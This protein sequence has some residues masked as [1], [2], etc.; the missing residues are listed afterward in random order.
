MGEALS[1]E[2]VFPLPARVGAYRPLARIGRGGVADVYAAIDPLGEL[3]ALKVQHT[4]STTGREALQREFQIQAWVE[5]P[6]LVTAFD[7]GVL[8]DGRGWIALEHV[9][10][11]VARRWVGDERVSGTLR[12]WRTLHVIGQVAHALEALHARGLV[13]AD[14][15]PSNLLV[16]ADGT[17]RLMDLGMARLV[18][19][20]W[21]RQGHF[22]GTRRYASP[23]QLRGDALTPAAD[24]FALGATTYALLRGSSPF[25][26]ELERTDAPPPPRLRGIHPLLAELLLAT[27]ESDPAARPA[28]DEL[29]EMLDELE[30]PEEAVAP[31]EPPPT[32]AFLPSHEQLQAL[33]AI[34]GEPVEVRVLAE[35]TATD[36]ETLVPLLDDLAAGGLADRDGASWFTEQAPPPRAAWND[37][38]AEALLQGLDPWPSLARAHALHHLDR[39][40]EAAAEALRAGRVSS[41]LAQV[42]H[43]GL[44][45]LRTARR[46]QAD[47]SLLDDHA[48]P[49]LAPTEDTPLGR[50]FRAARRGEGAQ[51]LRLAAAALAEGAAPAPLAMLRARGLLLSGRHSSARRL[52]E[53]AVKPAGERVDRCLLLI[54]LASVEHQLGRN[55]LARDLL[56]RA[57]GTLP[58]RPSNLLL[59]RWLRVQGEID[60]ATGRPPAADLLREAWV[61]A[62]EGGDARVLS[63]LDV[64]ARRDQPADRER[65]EAI[66][67]A[68][69]PGEDLPDLASALALSIHITGA[70]PEVPVDVAA[71]LERPGA[72]R[73][74]LQLL[75][76]AMERAPT[77]A[78]EAQVRSTA[79]RMLAAW[80]REDA[81]VFRRH[82]RWEPWLR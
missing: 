16:Q 38:L 28:L 43:P 65:E 54:E 46:V 68:T 10:G 59:A 13:H 20:D 50:G 5:H 44:A 18:D 45:K 49:S 60:A 78:L 12:A 4:R 74:Q 63:A 31:A 29:T 25:G 53:Q 41:R 58:A 15:K 81:H 51:A 11:V 47:R 67:A 79:R 7:T 57:R 75:L 19:G 21:V 73:W 17:A 6:A 14:I 27:L 2:S 77:A 55:Q 62:P 26:N 66:V 61:A 8:D 1:A 22:A 76:A 32:V 71:W 36:A 40:E 34:A 72:E 37:A 69:R 3:R 24:V 9:D 80:S 35:A 48:H 42:P 82:P 56:R 30:P 33:L 23:E 64:L 70:L 39:T 52:L